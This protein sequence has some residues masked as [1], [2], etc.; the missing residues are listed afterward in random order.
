MKSVRIRS[1]SGPY[2]VRMRENMDQNNSEYGHFLH[3]DISNISIHFRH[4]FGKN[5]SQPAF[6]FSELT[7][8]KFTFSELTG[9]YLLRVSIVNFEQVNA[10]LGRLV[11]RIERDLSL[12]VS[13]KIRF[14][15]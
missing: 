3:S 2:S 11:I 13:Q 12:E 6:T 14:S 4:L 8:L 1:Y 15:K 9:I 5:M 10:D 7:N